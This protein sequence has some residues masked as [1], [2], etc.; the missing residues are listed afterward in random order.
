MDQQDQHP[1]NSRQWW[2]EYFQGKWDHDGGAEHTRYFMGTVLSHLPEHERARHN[3]AFKHSFRSVPNG[4][5]I[6]A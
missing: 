1:V 3:V 4:G 6:Q 5:A 2:D